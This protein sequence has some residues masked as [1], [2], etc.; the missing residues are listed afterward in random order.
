M[1]DA[2]Q[3]AII[4]DSERM[5]TQWIRRLRTAVLVVIFCFKIEGIEIKMVAKEDDT[6]EGMGVSAGW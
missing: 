3:S 5:R 2:A 1:S 6:V 4:R